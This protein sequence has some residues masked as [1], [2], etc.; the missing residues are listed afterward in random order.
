MTKNRNWIFDVLTAIAMTGTILLDMMQFISAVACFLLA[1]FLAYSS[2]LK[3]EAF[4]S[5]ET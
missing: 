1:A 5:S 3:M 2:T 4:S